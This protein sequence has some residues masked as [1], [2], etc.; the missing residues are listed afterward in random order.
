M[1]LLISLAL[2][3]QVA[4]SCV[5][6][7]Q[8]A[9][10][11]NRA[12]GPQDVTTLLRAA[13]WQSNTE[14]KWEWY[15]HLYKLRLRTGIWTAA[16]IACWVIVASTQYVGSEVLWPVVGTDD[17]MD[18]T[19]LSTYL[20]VCQVITKREEEWR[21]QELKDKQ[22]GVYM[23]QSYYESYGDSLPPQF[24]SRTVAAWFSGVF[25]SIL[26]AT[27]I[28]LHMAARC[29]GKKKDEGDEEHVSS[30]IGSLRPSRFDKRLSLRTELILSFMLSILTGFNAVFCTG[31]QGPASKVGNLYY[32]SWFAYLLCVRIALGCLE[33]FY[34]LNDPENK[35]ASSP[36]RSYQAPTLASQSMDRGVSVV[37]RVKSNEAITEVSSN[38]AASVVSLDTARDTNAEKMEQLRIGHVRSYFFLSIFSVACTASAYDAASNTDSDDG[39]SRAQ[40]YM[41]FAPCY[42]SLQAIA[43]TTLCL[44]KRCYGF[45][46]SFA[47]GGVLSIVAFGLWLGNLF[48]TMHSDDS[49]AVNGIGE[50]EMANLYYFSWASILTAG[51]QMTSYIKDFLGIKMTDYMAAVWVGIIKVCF[52]ILGSSLH[53]WDT[54]HDKCGFDEI[55]MGA[56]TFCSRTILAICVALFGMIIGGL[57]VLVRLFL[58]TCKSC[59]CRRLQSHIEM[60]LSLLLLLIFGTAVAMITGIG[61][62]GQ[63]VGDLYYSTWLA[64][65][66]SMF[67]FI[68]CF[69]EMKRKDEISRPPLVKEMEIVE[70]IPAA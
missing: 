57:V 10:Q 58:M 45:V 28:G 5:R 8:R 13:S 39:L 43:M 40:K 27:A 26:C 46:S 59:Q 66:V 16:L 19:A 31:V 20:T 62:P 6:A 51:I 55:T 69:N 15:Q 60:I 21:M 53:I 17:K 25:A 49:W 54:I 64:F 9:Q 2:L 32:A 56:I 36:A 68:S 67:V 30:P 14:S 52:V 33:E 63:S 44:S 70:K 65:W 35:A 18:W 41:I 37:E 22:S 61:G 1:T 47:V 24:C 50:I 23:P 34:D 38:G 42:V 48:L 29:C 11:Q 12:E 7:Y 4:T 3:Y